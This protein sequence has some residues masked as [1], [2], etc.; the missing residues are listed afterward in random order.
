MLILCFC[1]AVLH[2]TSYGL[3]LLEVSS[4]LFVRVFVKLQGNF[5]WITMNLLVIITMAYNSPGTQTLRL[6]ESTIPGKRLRL[7][8]EA[9]LFSHPCHCQ[10]LFSSCAGSVVHVLLSSLVCSWEPDAFA[11]PALEQNTCVF[12]HF[13]RSKNTLLVVLSVFCPVL[14][15]SFF[16][17]PFRVS[18]LPPNLNNL[19][20]SHLYL[21][22]P[23]LLLSSDS[24]TNAWRF[25]ADLGVCLSRRST[26]A[27]I[28]RSSFTV[29]CFIFHIGTNFTSNRGLWMT[30]NMQTSMEEIK[31]EGEEGKQSD[32]ADWV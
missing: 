24:I 11:S 9:Q 25:S 30:R 7:A 22:V 20:V 5:T 15:S 12:L 3:V 14:P 29:V 18:S 27:K 2:P 16:L 26:G 13:R 6:V 23:A 1:L 8:D 31:T 21:I 32:G 19:Q 17:P 28:K 4:Y 10:L